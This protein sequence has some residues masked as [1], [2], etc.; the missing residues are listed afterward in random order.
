[1]SVSPYDET[2][3][4]LANEKRFQ[5]IWYN[6]NENT[7]FET[8]KLIVK[9]RGQNPTIHRFKIKIIIQRRCHV[10]HNDE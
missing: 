2:S 1:M 8:E 9:Y 5:Y 10:T 6:V 4:I 3:N 7:S